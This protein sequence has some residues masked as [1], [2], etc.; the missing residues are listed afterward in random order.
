MMRIRRM[1]HHA[2]RVAARAAVGR[3]EA[4]AGGAARAPAGV[5]AQHKISPTTR[6]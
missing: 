5:P 6:G 3:M 4:R 2:T 1:L